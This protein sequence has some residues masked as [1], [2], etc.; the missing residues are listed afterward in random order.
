M[1]DSFTTAIGNVTQKNAD[2][3]PIDTENHPLSLTPMAK[4]GAF[5]FSTR[6]IYCV[7]P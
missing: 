2:G 3:K 4:P 5:H 7:S 6:G 1:P